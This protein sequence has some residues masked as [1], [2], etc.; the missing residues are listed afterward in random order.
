[1]KP[2]IKV[3]AGILIDSQDQI[4]IAQRLDSKSDL[5]G[6][7]EFPGGK[8]EPGEGA[9]AALCRELQEELAI[10]VGSAKRYMQLQHEYP[11]K[12]VEL[13]FW[14][15]FH[16]RGEPSSAEQ[17][18]LKW[19]QRSQLAGENILPSDAPLVARL[20]SA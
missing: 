2:T 8:R 20:K 19:V 6:F 16:W 11:D 17:Q 1:M 3:V 4:L 7:W 15:V 5:D 14:R 9:F 12:H 18:P 10:E 13:D